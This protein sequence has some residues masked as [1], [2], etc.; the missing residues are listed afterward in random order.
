[1]GGKLEEHFSREELAQKL[2]TL[3]ESMNKPRK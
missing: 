1:M 2:E 3:F